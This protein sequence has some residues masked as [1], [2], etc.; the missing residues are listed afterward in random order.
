MLVMHKS[1]HPTEIDDIRL[2]CWSLEF[3]S[4]HYY[5]ILV[6]QKAARHVIKKLGSFSYF[7]PEVNI[8]VGTK[9][10]GMGLEEP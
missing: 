10:G 2:V 1:S 8:E 9:K 7:Q 6:G 5:S 4:I 3:F